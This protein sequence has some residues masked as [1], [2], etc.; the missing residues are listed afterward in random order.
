[1]M[2][3]GWLCFF[4]WVLSGKALALVCVSYSGYTDKQSADAGMRE[5]YRCIKMRSAEHGL[6]TSAIHKIRPLY[7]LYIFSSW[8]SA[9]LLCWVVVGIALSNLG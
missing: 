7:W 2:T 3:F 1:M 6:T 8:L 9:A 4:L 5:I